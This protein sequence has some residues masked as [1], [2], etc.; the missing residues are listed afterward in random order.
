MLVQ[1]SELTGSQALRQ[2]GG[3]L[4]CESL[5]LQ[6]PLLLEKCRCLWP[7][8]EPDLPQGRENVLLAQEAKPLQSLQSQHRKQ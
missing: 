6:L 2:R 7:Q 5:L 3:A 1:I 4:D 8:L